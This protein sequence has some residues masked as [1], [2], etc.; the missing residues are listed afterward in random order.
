MKEHLVSLL[1]GMESDLGQVEMFCEIF[2]NNRSI[3]REK[4]S[5]LTDDFIKTIKANGRQAKFLEFFTII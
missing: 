1:V 2:R 5:E 3:C 4:Y